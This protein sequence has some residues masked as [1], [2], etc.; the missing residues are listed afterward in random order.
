VKRKNPHSSVDVKVI[1]IGAL[2]RQ[3]AGQ[4]AA[5]GVGV[6]KGEL[7]LCLVWPG[8]TFERLWSVPSPGQLGTF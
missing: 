1:S 3:G 4:K 2:T 6:A 7:V 8:R 5:V